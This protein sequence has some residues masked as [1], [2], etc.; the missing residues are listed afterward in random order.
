MKPTWIGFVNELL[1]KRYRI[2]SI[3]IVAA[4]TAGSAYAQAKPKLIPAWDAS[5]ET[6][7]DRIDHGS[8]Q[9]L[10]DRY[11]RVHSSGINRFDYA[12]LKAS[13]KD[14]TGLADYLAHLQGLDPRE[15]SRAEQKAYWINFYNALTVQVVL[16]AYPVD[17]I[18]DISDSFLG[19]LMF[20]GPWEDV[21]AH[22]AGLDLTLDDIEHGILRPIY[23]DNRIHY[24]VN[25]AS[26]GCPNLL[27]TAFTAANTETLLDTGSREYVNHPRGVDFVD[28]DFIVISSIYDWFVEDFD[29]SEE[30]AI[31]HLIQ[32][33]D[34]EL[35][36]RLR[37]FEGSVDYDYD[38]GLNQP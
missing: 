29:G 16:E 12:A 33:A 31:K 9:N 14:I 23:R 5:N 11:L 25:C 1:G 21:V 38:W 17:S 28:D 32:Y 6:S 8:W 2:A 36:E 7:V 19:G 34:K 20:S 18:R 24:A 37:N 4:L 22:V 10:L 30:G 27:P 13:A 3:L 35:A 26:L 15:Y